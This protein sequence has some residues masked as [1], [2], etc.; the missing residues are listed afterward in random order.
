MPFVGQKVGRDETDRPCPDN[1]H[2][3][4]NMR[5]HGVP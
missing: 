5:S 4:L 2:V 3:L 1:N